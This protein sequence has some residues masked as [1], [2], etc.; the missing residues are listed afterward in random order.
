MVDMYRDGNG[1]FCSFKINA[2]RTCTHC[3][4]LCVEGRASEMGDV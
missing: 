1:E 4:D 2:R 3:G